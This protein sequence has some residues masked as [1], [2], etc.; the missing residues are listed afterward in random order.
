MRVKELIELLKKCNPDYRVYTDCEYEATGM[1]EKRDLVN[2]EESYV[3][4]F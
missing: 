1:I 2:E 4:I 3:Q